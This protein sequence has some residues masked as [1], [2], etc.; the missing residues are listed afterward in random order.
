MPEKDLDTEKTDLEKVKTWNWEHTKN[1]KTSQLI[2]LIFQ[3]VNE[4]VEELA[5]QEQS[6]KDK[7]EEIAN[8]KKQEETTKKELASFYLF[9][10]LY[11]F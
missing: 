5:Q 1:S 4:L 6:V 2:F 9:F 11:L 7:D 10:F 3:R 8:L